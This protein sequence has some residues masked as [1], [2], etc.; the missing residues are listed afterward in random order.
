M[1]HVGKRPIV[2]LRGDDVETVV[3]RRG[4]L[5]LFLARTDRLENADAVPLERESTM[6]VVPPNAAERVPDSNVSQV[7]DSPN[8]FSMC[9]WQSTPPGKTNRPCASIT[10]T[11]GPAG[12]ASPIATTRPSS[13]IRSAT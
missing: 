4:S 6:V 10:F 7:V 5:R 8:V 1:P 12:S 13:S 3:D 9:V 2:D 11:S